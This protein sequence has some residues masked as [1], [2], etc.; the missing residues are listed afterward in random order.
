MARLHESFPVRKDKVYRQK[1]CE[2]SRRRSNVNSAVLHRAPKSGVDERW[3]RFAI[4]N[5][6]KNVKGYP[7]VNGEALADGNWE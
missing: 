3:K 5:T 1:Y 2:A 4:S 6:S 7:G